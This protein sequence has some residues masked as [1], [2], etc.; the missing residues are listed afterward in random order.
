MHLRVFLALFSL[1]RDYQF[2][3]RVL[4]QH[5]PGLLARRCFLLSRQARRFRHAKRSNLPFQDPQRHGIVITRKRGRHKL[6]RIFR[7][8]IHA[9]IR[10]GARRTG[11]LCDLA[12]ISTAAGLRIIDPPGIVY[13]S[14]A[15]DRPAVV[16]GSAMLRVRRPRH[17]QNPRRNK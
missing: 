11:P 5:D 15:V 10:T 16:Y 9:S 4:F 17:N 7:V 1:L 8:P 13:I 12:G 6:S 3:A 2:P 14:G